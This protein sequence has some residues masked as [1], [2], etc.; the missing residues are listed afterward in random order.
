MQKPLLSICRAFGANIL[1]AICLVLFPIVTTAQGN[2][3]FF[4]DFD[5]LNSDRWLVSD[6]WVNGNWQN[7]E[8]TA[9]ALGVRDGMLGLSFLPQQTSKRDYMCGE[10]Q[11][12]GFYGFGTFEARMK[13]PVGS[14][15]NAAFFSYT[16]PPHG[17][18]HDEIDFEILTRDT[19][20]VSLNTYVDGAPVNG[21]TVALPIPADSGF[22]TYSFTWDS[23]GVAWFVDGVLVHKTTTGSATPITPQK[24]YASF[25]GSDTLVNWMGKFEQ[26]TGSLVSKL[27][28]IAFTA[29]GE[30]CQFPASVLCAVD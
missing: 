27:D 30:G 13:T 1:I 3:S 14:G 5:E 23:D 2:V 16:G 22:I 12:R 8:W 18:P 21:K 20:R 25:W 11:S 26:P 10:I 15:M 28:W 29:L 9:Q 19:T 6:G 4:D 7:C 17:N 24:I